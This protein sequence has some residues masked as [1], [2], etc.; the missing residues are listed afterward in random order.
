MPEM[1]RSP[2]A[3]VDM[4]RITPMDRCQHAAQTVRIA[5]HEN[6]GDMVG[7]QHPGPDL[8]L[9][10]RRLL[11]KEV[12]IGRMILVLEKGLAAAVAALG[13]MMGDS[14]KDCARE[15]SPVWKGSAA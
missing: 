9:G 10:R 5:G 4:A 7:H 13:Q 14:R 1:P 2:E 8:H 12:A 3:G 11:G 6:E 15:P